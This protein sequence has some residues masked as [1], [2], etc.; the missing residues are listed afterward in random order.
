MADQ[1]Y[2]DGRA[3][4]LEALLVN[5]AK[6]IT[7]LHDQGAPRR[8]YGALGLIAL[9][10][11]G[12]LGY[13]ATRRGND[14]PSAEREV[15]PAL[16]AQAQGHLLGSPDAPVKIIEFSDFECPYCAQF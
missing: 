3:R 13:A 16:A 2:D 7:E 10:G 15:D 11:V 9:V 1:T 5:L 12:A 4:N 6:R 8:F 14:T